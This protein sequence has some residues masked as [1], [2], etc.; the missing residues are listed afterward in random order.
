MVKLLHKELNSMNVVDYTVCKKYF[1][2]SLLVKRHTFK[3]YVALSNFQSST[4]GLP[5]TI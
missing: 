1:S 4:L 2:V 3:V 5:P